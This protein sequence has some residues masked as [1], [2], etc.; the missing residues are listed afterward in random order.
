MYTTSAFHSETNKVYIKFDR[1]FEVDN[2]GVPCE[3]TAA[4]TFN[5]LQDI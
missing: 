3:T 5:Q 1:T 2:M 4:Q